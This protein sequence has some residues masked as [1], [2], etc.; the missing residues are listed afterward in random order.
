MSYI[1]KSYRKFLAVAAT[2]AVVT[3]AASPAASAAEVKKFPDVKESHW[4]AKEI[5][6]LVSAG[7]IKGYEDGTFKP[8]QAIIRGQ[9]AHLLAEALELPVP[10]NLEVFSDVSKD[11]FY[12]KS[13]AAAKEA[14]IFEG[15]YG[16]FGLKDELT[17]EQMASV[18]VRAFDLKDNNTEVSFTDWDKIKEVHQEDVKILAQHGITIG[19]KDGSFDPA[20]PVNRASFAAFLYRALE[21]AKNNDYFELSLMHTNDTHAHLDSVAKRATAINEVRAEKPDA[22]LLD[23][24]DVMSGTLYFNEYKGQADLEFMNMLGY[25]A[26]TFGNHEFDLGSSPEGHKALTEFVKGASFPLVSSNVDFSKDELFNGLF[27]SGEVTEKPADGNIYNGIIKEVNGEKIGIFGLTT[28]ETADISS[29]EKVEFKNY[30]E[31]AEKTVDAFEEKGVDKIIALSH[32]GYDDNAAYDNDLELAKYVDGIDVIVGGHSHTE[33]DK[34]VVI[35][36]DENGA[37]KDPTIIVQ[38]YQYGDFLGTLDVDFDDEGK[39]VGQAGKL[40]KVADQK[41][42][43]KAAQLLKKYSDKISEVKNTESGGTAVKA[44]ANPRT[45]EGSTISVRNS[46]TELGNLITDGMLDKAKELKPETVIAMQNAGGIR[47]PIDEGSITLGDILTVM[48]FG[49]T[50]ATMKLTGA[51]ITEA[52][53]HSVSQAPKENG[54]F[55]HV[56]GLKV[57]YDSSKPAGSRVVSVEV[58]EKEGEFTALDKTKEYTIATNAFT[59]KGGDGFDVFADAYAAGRVT[60]LGLADWENLRD[61]VAKLKTVEPKVEGRIVDVAK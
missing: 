4:A 34:P 19:M 14:G 41:E 30:I 28:A 24:G 16:K 20:S 7:I 54:G 40:I 37:V 51:E 31:E 57:K 11:S 29:P 43:P 47:A 18:L 60:D 8:G 9:A 56:S 36:K 32:L 44:L 12:A 38:A 45:G 15:A 61:Y 35:M 22:L 3:S 50:L 6:A 1:P 42:D 33:L 52:L 21:N 5:Q 53:E 13:I 17:R 25:D 39:V 46:E 49:N 27:H 48:P 55:L 2:A 10:A 23:A 59:A 58:E 26:M